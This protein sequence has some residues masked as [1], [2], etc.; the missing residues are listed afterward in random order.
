MVKKLGQ[1]AFG[2]VKLVIDQRNGKPY[3][4][5]IIKKALFKKRRLGMGGP[6]D[7]Q[8]KIMREIAIMKRLRH[9]NVVNLYEVIDDPDHNKLY[10]VLDYIEGGCMLSEED[11]DAGVKLPQPKARDYFRDVVRGLHYLHSQG[12]LHHDLKPEN[13][14]VSADNTVSIGDFGV[15]HIFAD[16]DR[17]R[18]IPG[19]PAFVAPECIDGE[20]GGIAADI[21]SLGVCL[22]QF[23]TGRVPFNAPSV[24]E[25]FEMISTSPV[26]IPADLPV[27]LA[28]LIEKLLNKDPKKRITLDAVMIHPWV[29]SSGTNPL[30]PGEG[31]NVTV[32]DN[33]VNQAVSR[34][35]IM[36]Q[37][38][39][40]MLVE[41]TYKA[42]DVIVK[43]GDVGDEMF[44]INEG[45]V[46]VLGDDS[47]TVVAHR[48]S[49]CF[50]GE[51]ALLIS[52]TRTATVRAASD[53]EMLVLS[54]ENLSKMLSENPEE[55]KLLYETAMRRREELV[56]YQEGDE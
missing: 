32:T 40:D 54:R 3:A 22:F 48:K 26:Q 9:R 24:D 36:M 45:H 20:F 51:M 11:R 13:L 30:D 23:V 50:I 12:V 14:L 46:H 6:S 8:Q 18:T 19:T 31:V 17:V 27:E 16:D 39:S 38:S 52:E 1:G 56:K 10:M 42:G 29:T 43:K 44:F 34:S 15:S 4:V 35:L 53:V 28:D 33:E 37:K 21:W 47:Q 5:K 55:R 41:R 2:K 7:N 49:G 25:M